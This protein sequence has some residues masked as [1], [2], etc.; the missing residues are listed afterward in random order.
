MRG[1]I[2]EAPMPWGASAAGS[3]V[4]NECSFPVGIAA[5]FPI[6]AV[7][8]TDVEQAVVVWGNLGEHRLP[9]SQLET[10]SGRLPSGRN[11]LA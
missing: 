9:W 10:F 6:D 1:W 7:V 11:L 8:V 3:A 2:E 5:G 4:E